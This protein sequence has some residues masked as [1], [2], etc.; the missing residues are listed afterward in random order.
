LIN[1]RGLQIIGTGRITGAERR[2]HRPELVLDP[3]KIN[4]A[5]GTRGKRK[6]FMS[7]TSHDTF[8]ETMKDAVTAWK[9]VLKVGHS[10][11]IVSKPNIECIKYICKELE[12][13][14]KQVTF[15]FTITSDRQDILDIWEPLSPDFN[16]RLGCLEYAHESG[17]ET[18][19]SIEPF[20]SD[21]VSTVGHLL[22]WTTGETWIGAMN[23][24]PS[25]KVLGHAFTD[26]E[27]NEIQRLKTV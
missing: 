24:F 1:T 13:Y 15:R 18:S 5:W 26:R 3:A 16:E 8:P 4:K 27:K 6:L 7:P 2:K 12:P 10:L 25:E 9:S 11:L 23:T 19:V 14:K 20:L 21:P 17:Y 22:A